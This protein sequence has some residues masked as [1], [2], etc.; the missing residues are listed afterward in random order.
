MMGLAGQLP[1]LQGAVGGCYLLAAG[2][3]LGQQRA[4]RAA[5][6]LAAA[7]G[8]GHVALLASRWQ[9]QGQLP[10]VTRYEDLTMDALAIVLVFLLAQWRWPTLRRPGALVLLLAGSGVLAA[11]AYS[12]AHYPWSPALRTVWLVI[13]AQLNSLA[14]AMGV[15]AAASTLMGGQ[16]ARALCGRLL[17]WTLW[18]WAAMIAA[19]SYWAHL[20]WGR[21]WGWDPIESWALATALAYAAVLHLMLRRDWTGIK[22]CRLALLPFGLML[23]TTYGLLLVRRSLHGQYLFT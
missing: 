19:G 20:A 22:G 5:L 21:F 11:L 3:L 23:F 1:W 8:V 16:A 7:A 13:H 10:I 14:I 18:L 9:A 12:Q 17:W 15:L 6:A 2:L 4:Q